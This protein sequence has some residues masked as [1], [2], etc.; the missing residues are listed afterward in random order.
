MKTLLLISILVLIHIAG[1]SQDVYDVNVSSAKGMA[2]KINGQIIVNFSDSTVAFRFAG[3]ET[4]KRIVN[5]ANPVIY[6]T[7][8]MAIDKLTISPVGGKIKGFDY[9]HT[10]VLDPDSRF[11]PT[12]IIYFAIKR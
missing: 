5:N 10:L 8:G 2:F 1:Y 6:L 7:D 9:N 11:N 4:L 12:Q 3:N